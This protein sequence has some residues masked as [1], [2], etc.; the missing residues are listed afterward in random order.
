MERPLPRF[1]PSGCYNGLRPALDTEF[2]QDR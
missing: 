2:L 1:D